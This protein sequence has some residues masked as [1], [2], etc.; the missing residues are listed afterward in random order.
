METIACE[1]CSAPIGKLEEARVWL[2]RPVCEACDARIRAKQRRTGPALPWLAGLT[3]AAVAALLLGGF[4]SW[5]VLAAPPVAP[6][7][8]S[9]PS[10]EVTRYDW[11]NGDPP[12]R[13]I[14]KEEGFCYLTAVCG[15]FNG[16]GE[17]A[18]VYVD[19]DGYWC[20]GGQ[21]GTGFLRLSAV[22]VRRP[23]AKYEAAAKPAA[24]KPAAE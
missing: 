7:A 16:G 13:M 15:G 19:D 9:A 24:A 3:A 23:V 5:K 8:P 22:S 1:N 14:R 17:I 20:L 2:D 21:T 10:V 11:A 18:N 4:A 6:T 12:I